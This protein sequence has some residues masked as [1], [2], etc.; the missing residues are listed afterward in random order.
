MS[1]RILTTPD[2]AARWAT[3]SLG[4]ATRRLHNCVAERSAAQLAGDLRVAGGFVGGGVRWAAERRLAELRKAEVALRAR[5]RAGAAERSARNIFA[6]VA[7]NGYPSAVG[8]CKHEMRGACLWLLNEV[9]LF[10]DANKLVGF[11][12]GEF[13]HA[14]A[15]T[16]GADGDGTVSMISNPTSSGIR[17]PP[18]TRLLRYAEMASRTFSRAS[19]RVSPHVWQPGSAGTYAWNVSPSS[20][21]TM[22]LYV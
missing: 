15:A 16:R 19:S 11:D 4:A 1:S 8:V 22:I 21:S 3:T 5:K 20:G 6:L 18:A 2:E 17:S 12:S 7:G 13:C 9:Q 10:E 14:D